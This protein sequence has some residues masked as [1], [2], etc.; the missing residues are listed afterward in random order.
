MQR[1]D[2]IGPGSG[3]LKDS[4]NLILVL[5]D[6]VRIAAIA[7]KVVRC[8]QSRTRRSGKGDR[9]DVQGCLASSV[10]RMMSPS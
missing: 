4:V 5:P 7:Q 2:L 9:T 1:V 10:W 6:A 8:G 3:D